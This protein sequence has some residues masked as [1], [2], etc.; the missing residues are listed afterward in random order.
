MAAHV[1]GASDCMIDGSQALSFVVSDD[2][3]TAMAKLGE[4]L[5][6]AVGGEGVIGKMVSITSGGSEFG[7]GIIGWN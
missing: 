4:R 5:E 7:D 2:G 3:E 6:L 1:D